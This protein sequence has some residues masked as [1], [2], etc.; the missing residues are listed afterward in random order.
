MSTPSS[1]TRSVKQCR[2]AGVVHGDVPLGEQALIR[3]VIPTYAPG[4]DK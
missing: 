1:A 4:I 3:R 2:T